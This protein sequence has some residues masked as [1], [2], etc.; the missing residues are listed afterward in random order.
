MES[1]RQVTLPRATIVI[2]DDDEAVCKSLKFSLE[3][4]GYTV[5]TYAT[6]AELLNEAQLPEHGCL[7]LDYGLS[8]MNGLE[9]L[10]HLRRDRH[11]NLP[12]IIVTTHADTNLRKR[13]AAAGTRLV[14]K[15]LIGNALPDAIDAAL[16]Q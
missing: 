11:C 12:A 16:T 15:P 10:G 5:R 8:G 3:V 2:V 14:E 1:E 4:E 9:L 7:I 6:G 13:M